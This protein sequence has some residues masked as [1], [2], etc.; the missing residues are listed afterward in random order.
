[1]NG[2]PVLPDRGVVLPGRDVDGNDQSSEKI[3]AWH[4][5]QAAA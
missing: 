3:A 5:A 2:R 1:V 4:E